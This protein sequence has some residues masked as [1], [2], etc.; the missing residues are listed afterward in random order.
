MRLTTEIQDVI[1]SEALKSLGYT[2]VVNGIEYT[3]SDLQDSSYTFTKE[4]L[5][6]WLNTCNWSIGNEC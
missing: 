2:L 6:D 3:V 1:L 5:V 4:D